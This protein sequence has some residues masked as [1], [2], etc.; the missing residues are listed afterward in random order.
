M[1]TC[2]SGDEMACSAGVEKYK[3]V[4]TKMLSLCKFQID[5][6]YKIKTIKNYI[7]KKF[8]WHS[9]PTIFCCRHS[10]CSNVVV[11]RINQ[12]KKAK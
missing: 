10:F 7:K 5:I 4:V 12:I 9:I 8:D 11:Q 6:L 2:C 1:R 3:T